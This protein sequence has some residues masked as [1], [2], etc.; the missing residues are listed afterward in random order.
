MLILAYH[1]DDIRNAIHEN[2]INAKIC[3]KGK[4]SNP[5]TDEQKNQNK[6]ISKVRSRVEPIFADIKSFD[7]DF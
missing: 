6:E 2:K 5:L 4:R 7:G 3:N 1:N